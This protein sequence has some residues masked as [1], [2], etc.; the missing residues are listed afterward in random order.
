MDISLVHDYADPQLALRRE[1]GVV[2]DQEPV[3][4]WNHL[5]HQQR[6]GC[7]VGQVD[8]REEAVATV[9]ELVA[10]ARVDFRGA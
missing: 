4:G 9:D 3:E 5:V 8:K 6:L 10:M 1:A 7:P 2:T